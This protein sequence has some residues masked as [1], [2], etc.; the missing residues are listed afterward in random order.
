VLM[1]L[2]ATMVAAPLTTFRV[3][4]GPPELRP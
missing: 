4:M 3:L 2:S 1:A